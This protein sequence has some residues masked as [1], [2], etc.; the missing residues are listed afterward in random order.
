MN[1]AGEWIFSDEA[2]RWQDEL[3]SPGNG[4]NWPRF[5][6][7]NGDNGWEYGLFGFKEVSPE[8]TSHFSARW[9]PDADC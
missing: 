9:T 6:M 4:L 2:H 1:E 5:Q 3:R 8:Y 7:E